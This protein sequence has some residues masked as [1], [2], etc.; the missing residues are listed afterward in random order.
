MDVVYAS[1]DNYARHLAVSMY[2]L[3]DNNQVAD[4]IR[5]FVLAV[6]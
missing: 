5:V 3:M 6:D 4:E 1:N 2:S